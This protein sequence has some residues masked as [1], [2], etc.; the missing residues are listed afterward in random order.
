VPTYASALPNEQFRSFIRTV[1]M[2]SCELGVM[3]FAHEMAS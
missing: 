3:P 1:T 2:L